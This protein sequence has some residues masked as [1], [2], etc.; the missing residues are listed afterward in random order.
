MNNKVDRRSFIKKTAAI[1]ISSL[2]GSN[3]MTKLSSFA[4]ENLQIDI[5]A[6]KGD[7]Y[8]NN[9][10]KAVD[11]LGGIKNF[12]SKGSKVGLLV[13]SP[14]KNPGSFTNPDIVLAVIKICYQAGAKEIISLE[15]ASSGYWNRTELSKKF[16]EELKSL[17]SAGKSHIKFEIP[18]GK[19]LKEAHIEKALLDC[20]VFINIPKIKDHAGTKFTGCLKNMMG[21]TAYQP[22]NHFIHFGNTGKNWQNGGYENV[23]WLSQCI[24]DL[25]LVRKPDLC[26]ADATEILLTNGPDGPGKLV[27]PLYIIAGT[28]PVAVDTYCAKFVNLTGKEI[29]LIKNASE[30]GLGD[31][32][33]A[34]LK[35]K[36]I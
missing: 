18:K 4:D 14:W 33:L 6:V 21:A 27:K 22:T 5:A 3:I 15:S 26:I 23:E 10:I 30:H 11:L 34:K 9:T 19:N 36:E 20:D 29:I 24:S 25:A 8:F 28:N 35:I 17:N 12:V 13:N 1:G 7:D 2:I 31:L 16:G 32:N